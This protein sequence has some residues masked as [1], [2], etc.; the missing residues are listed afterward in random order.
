MDSEDLW[1]AV[2][3]DFNNLMA[4]LQGVLDLSDPALPFDPRNHAR[5]GTILE[6]GKTLIAMARAVALGR[7]PATGAI[8][9]A[10]WETGLR[11]RL[12]PLGSLFGCPIDL[13]DAG[14]GGASWPAPL[15]QDWVAAFTRQ[16][17]PW[18]APGP[19]R[20][21]AEVTPE[22]WTFRWITDAPLPPALRP[23]PSPDTPRHMPSYWL[24]AMAIHMG[25]EA[26]AHPGFLEAR[27]PRKPAEQTPFKES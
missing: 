26:E 7:L 11:H 4:G 22:A 15:L 10:E 14:A 23:E 17:L 21:V 19:L 8:P 13:A 24:R 27:L 3:H 9:W 16:V 20:L 12:D 6:D 5:L 2:L 18:A 1:R 25:L